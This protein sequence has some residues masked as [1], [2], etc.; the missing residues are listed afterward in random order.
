MITAMLSTALDVSGDPASR[1]RLTQA[2][3][4]I[5]GPAAHL[6][7]SS[8]VDHEDRVVALTARAVLSARGRAKS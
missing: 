4:E 7:L 8:L 6:A 3:S 5:P 2:L 1:S